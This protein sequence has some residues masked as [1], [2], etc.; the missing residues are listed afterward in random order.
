[1]IWLKEDEKVVGYV[2]ILKKQ[3]SEEEIWK[4]N[5]YSLYQGWSEL[6]KIVMQI[7]GIKYI[8]ANPYTYYEF[9]AKRLVDVKFGFY[10]EFGEDNFHYI[11]QTFQVFENLVFYKMEEYSKTEIKEKVSRITS[12][13]EQFISK[14]TLDDIKGD[15]KGLVREAKRNDKDLCNLQN[16]F[17]A[18]GYKLSHSLFESPDELLR[19]QLYAERAIETELVMPRLDE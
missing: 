10:F 16:I 19:K 13:M 11:S 9:E 14:K 2:P 8:N 5:K 7:Q 3:Y 1:M 12:E 18:N 15:I 6:A 17:S 4:M